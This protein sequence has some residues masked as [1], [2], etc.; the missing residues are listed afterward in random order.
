MPVCCLAVRQATYGP[1]RSPQNGP[2]SDE[3]ACKCP[4]FSQ[5]LHF[6]AYQVIYVFCFPY[7]D[8]D[9][10]MHQ[11]LHVLDASGFSQSVP[12]SVWSWFHSFVS[13]TP[14]LIISLNFQ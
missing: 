7:F 6:F 10:F 14:P 11:I 13:G 3:K 5:N 12:L 2:V 8:R 4:P 9:A 1:Y